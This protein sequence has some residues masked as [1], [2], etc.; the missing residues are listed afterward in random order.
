MF[1]FRTGFIANEEKPGSNDSCL[2]SLPL[3]AR[4]PLFLP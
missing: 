4:P 2:S 1:L 3:S